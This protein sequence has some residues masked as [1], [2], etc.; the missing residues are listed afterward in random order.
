[1]SLTTIRLISVSL[2]FSPFGVAQSSDWDKQLAAGRD[3]RALGRYGEAKQVFTSL[4]RETEK[5]SGAPA[6]EAAVL[7]NLAVTE[8][9]LGNFVAAESLLTRSLSMLKKPGAATDTEIAPVESHLGEVYLEEG[10][11]RDAEPLFRR[12]LQARQNATEPDPLNLAV[13]LADLA[14]ARKH[15]GKPGEA[16]TL[17]RQAVAILEERFGPDHPL[18]A[19]ALGPLGS[20]LTKE[21]RYKEALSLTERTWRILR[22]DPRVSEPDLLNTMST[23]GLLYSMTG[24]FQDAEFFAKEAVAKA[25]AIYGPDHMRLG[26]HLA[27]YADVLKRTGRKDEARAAQQRSAAILARNQQANPVRHTV[28]VNAL[29]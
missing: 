5:R 1:M 25:E 13:A 21:G 28:N 24:Q 19:S 2:I 17:L 9:D 20:T 12:V 23:L 7:D 3:L 6:L 26:W 22:K 18:V 15:L 10:R 4:L 11:P 8:Q 29:R 27:N 14:M 16:E